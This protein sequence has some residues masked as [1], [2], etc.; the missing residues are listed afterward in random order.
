MASSAAG[1]LLVAGSVFFF[2]GAAIAVPRVFS[3]PDREKRVRLL[4]AHPLLW[5]AGQPLY[6]A[7]ALVARGR[8]RTPAGRW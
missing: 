7:G 2:A 4:E 8:R 6:A 5:R 3:E 1:G